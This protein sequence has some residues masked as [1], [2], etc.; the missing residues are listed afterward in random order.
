MDSNDIFH[1]ADHRDFLR[2]YLEGRKPSQGVRAL[3]RKAGIK[4]PGQLTL[5]VQGDRRLTARSAD[6]LAKAL[7]LKGRRRALLLAFARLDSG[8]SEAEK[9]AARE[10]IIRLKSFREEFQLS[11][12]QYSF[13]AVWYYP[14][15]YAMLE[16][17]PGVVD[18]AAFAARLGR[19]VSAS[20]VD[21]ALADLSALGLITGDDAGAW[22]TTQASLTT[23]QDV[24]DLAAAKYHRNVLGL[25]EQALSLPLTEREFGGITMA[26]PRRLLPHVKERM[27]ALRR[28][29]NELAAQVA[30][31]ADIYQL[32]LQLFPVTNG[33]ERNPLEHN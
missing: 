11:A 18:P 16:N 8:K 24:Q 7:A 25:A 30:T 22:C 4:S 27:R 17:A 2:R 3:A 13:L 19:G 31:P 12:K 33:I 29:L 6:L 26:L 9:S 1:C 23:P 28:E 21:A 10:E 32:N 14:V 20:Q 15:I 5:I